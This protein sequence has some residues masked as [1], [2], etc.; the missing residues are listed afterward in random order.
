MS[1]HFLSGQTYSDYT[2][3]GPGTILVDDGATVNATGTATAAL[4]LSSGPWRIKIDGALKA[5][6]Y[7]A[8]DLYG[9]SPSASNVVIGVGADISADG[10]VSA[11]VSCAHALNL[12]NA[13]HLTGA[14]TGI[15]G[16]G[17]GNHS[18]KNLKTGVIESDTF[19]IAFNGGKNTISNAGTISGDSYA[20]VGGVG[21][22]KVTN[23]GLIAGHVSLGL[24]NDVFTNFKKVGH[25][26]KPGAVTGTI[27]LGAGNDTFNG[28]NTREFVKD[29]EGKD[30]YKLG[31][32]N[33]HFIG[34]LNGGTDRTD[35]VNGGKGIDAYDASQAGLL[36]VIINLDDKTHFD[37]FYSRKIAAL[38]A[39]DVN[40]TVTAADKIVS[41]ENAYGS[42]GNDS[43]FGT[44]RANELVGGDGIDILYGLAGNDR[45]FG[46]NDP[47]VLVG[48][49]GKDE[50]WGGADGDLFVF[51]S[52][53]DSGPTA[54]TR[55]TIKDFG[56]GD[57]IDLHAIN[58]KLGDIVTGFLGVDVDFT[59]HKG[60]LR[61]VTEGAN[62]IVELDVNGD[63]KADFTIQLDGHHALTV[64]DFNL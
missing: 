34:Y 59:G 56:V 6:G 50:L 60:D 31:G 32:G 24:G 35:T 11:G 33:D 62:T 17:K 45:L 27:D 61:A 39:D 29:F 37:T 2:D 46:N 7:H 9:S 21:V 13:G 41:I 1:F 48:G 5:D 40:N 20:V 25:G 49:A 58:D 18:V 53:K 52:L 15:S 38:R 26:I 51:Q 28:G 43:M 30:L 47:D 63:K 8:I 54:A 36:D 44:Q 12:T 19:G 3:T 55:D 10:S 23:F 22:D 14:R 64:D 57:T 42:A 16:Y 4:T